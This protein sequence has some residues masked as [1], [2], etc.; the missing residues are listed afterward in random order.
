[1]TI[2]KHFLF[3]ALTTGVA[4]FLIGQANGQQQMQFK[5]GDRVEIDVIMAGSPERSIYKK[6]TVTAVDEKDRSY[7]V[8]IDPLPGKLPQ[9]YRIPVRDYGKYW[10]RAVAGGTT[11]TAP[12]IATDRLRID[13]N[14]TVLA[15]REILDCEHLAHT[16]RNGSPLPFELA[17]KLIRCTIERPS[18]PG[19]DGA[20]IMDI[21]EFAPG[22]AR[23]W[24]LYED[25]GQG[26][27]NT[28]VY[29]VHVRW[30]Q[31]TFY[32]TRNLAITD[33]EGMFTCFVDNT[34]V[35]QCGS[36]AGPRKDG[37]TQEIRVIK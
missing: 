8:D 29:P 13:E 6:G 1:M 24:K 35:W 7:V 27:L 36:A 12:T 14:G 26:S 18:Q 20:Q 25:M 10:I 28:L 9:Q 32:R 11:R 16:G 22:A 4:F 23:R 30:N 37:K 19:M 34:G 2:R 5:V 17:K 21:T 31:K 3:A 33:K 15:D